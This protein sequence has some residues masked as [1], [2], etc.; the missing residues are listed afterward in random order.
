MVYWEFFVAG[1]LEFTQFD[2]V[3]A[4]KR[5]GLQGLKREGISIKRAGNKLNWIKILTKSDII[6][7]GIGLQAICCTSNRQ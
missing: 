3:V 6:G 7:I 2:P 4:E 1:K 5:S